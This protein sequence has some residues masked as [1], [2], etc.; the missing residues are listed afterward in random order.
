MIG[1]GGRLRFLRDRRRSGRLYAAHRD[2]RREVY[3]ITH[4]GLHPLPHSGFRSDAPFEWGAADEGALELSY[5][6]LRDVRRRFTSDGVVVDLVFDLVAELPRDGFV[7]SADDVRRWLL[8]RRRASRRESPAATVADAAWAT[9]QCWLF[10]F[11][12]TIGRAAAQRDGPGEQSR[13]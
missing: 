13:R 5:A 6:L 12:W 1:R 4:D 11:A 7:L 2:P 9:T 3:V 8:E 10:P